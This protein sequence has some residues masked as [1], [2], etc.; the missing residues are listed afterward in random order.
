MGGVSGEKERE[1]RVSRTIQ[2]GKGRVA[3]LV[4]V[5]GR[6]QKTGTWE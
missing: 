4:G 2:G 5:A 3:C 1:K 6:P